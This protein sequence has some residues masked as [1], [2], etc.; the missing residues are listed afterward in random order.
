MGSTGSAD[1]MLASLM[2]NAAK[3][4]Q[5]PLESEVQ[6]L[7]Q[8]IAALRTLQKDTNIRD[9][10]EHA[11]LESDEEDLTTK[12][13]SLEQR[14]Q[15]LKADT[16]AGVVLLEKYIEKERGHRSALE[17]DLK[18]FKERQ[19]ETN[20]QQDQHSKLIDEDVRL[21]QE[22]T[23]TLQAQQR[24]DLEEL[25]NKHQNEVEH[26]KGTSRAAKEAMEA[27]L[28]E[29]LARAISNMGADMKQQVDGLTKQFVGLNTKV[30][31]MSDHFE[32]AKEVREETERDLRATV[33][34][35][36]EEEVK[37]QVK[38]EVKHEVERQVKEEVEGQMKDEVE[39]AVE[40]EVA[41][42]PHPA[43]TDPL[44]Q[45]EPKKKRKKCFCL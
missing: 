39:E 4:A 41:N 26:L 1:T 25:A 24:K 27:R 29:E 31:N 30:G 6:A 42:M 40:M 32:D 2:A 34:S 37:H 36:V 43:S 7:K 10:E 18:S 14:L 22:A 28:H 5:K 8:E 17:M 23:K 3:E 16:D 20:L 9:A 33:E 45:T 12:T 13:A 38:T 44:N 15:V 21:L 19:E 35:E 11:K